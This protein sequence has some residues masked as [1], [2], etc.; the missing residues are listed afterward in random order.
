M[1]NYLH[2]RWHTGGGHSRR[3]W[4]GHQEP[5][6]RPCL[7]CIFPNRRASEPQTPEAHRRR[8][9][10]NDDNGHGEE[11]VP[12]GFPSNALL[13]WAR[14][15][16]LSPAV[17]LCS[18]CSNLMCLCFF[19]LLMERRANKNTTN[20]RTRWSIYH[21]GQHYSG[22]T[23]R[24]IRTLNI[25]TSSVNQLGR[26]FLLQ[27]IWWLHK[28]SRSFSIEKQ[29]I[30]IYMHITDTGINQPHSKFCAALYKFTVCHEH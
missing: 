2:H 17:I 15:P 4:V 21:D 13:C 3:D 24:K 14:Q 16:T 8:H 30:Q 28:N 7:Y 5:P 18:R 26:L 20:F 19:L 23:I 12:G 6:L 11:T 1:C 10:Y 25:F 27:A 9:L 29:M 22:S